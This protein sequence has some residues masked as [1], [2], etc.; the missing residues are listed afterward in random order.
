MTTARAAFVSSFLLLSACAAH[1]EDKKEAAPAPQGEVRDLP[2]FRGVSVSHGIQAEV[3]TGSR[4]VRLEGPPELLKRV[5]LE[6]KDGMLVTH[7]ERQGLFNTGFGNG[8]VRL[9]V[10]NPKVEKVSA[11]GGAGIEAEA[12]DADEFSAEA[13]G[14]AT[15]NVRDVDARKVD[16]EASGGS[17]VTLSGRAQEL[18]AEASGGAVVKA[19]DVKGVKTLAAEASG[20]SRVEADAS[21]SVKGEASGGSVIRL[22]SRPGQSDVDTSG[23][24]KVTYDK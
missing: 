4:S 12:T 8:K 11:S 17:R 1:A 23:G 21:E 9:Y 13:S 6:V 15:V 10:T 14:G 2:D 20:G 7:V 19:Q 5:K 16:A 18:D 3:K 24:S 22:V